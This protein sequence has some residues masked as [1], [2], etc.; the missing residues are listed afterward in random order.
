MC[1]QEQGVQPYLDAGVT[2]NL[3]ER[4]REVMGL[5]TRPGVNAMGCLSPGQHLLGSQGMG[6]SAFSPGRRG[7]GQYSCREQLLGRDY[8]LALR[9]R[10]G[11]LPADACW[12]RTLPSPGR[13]TVSLFQIRIFQIRIPD[14]HNT[15]QEGQEV[16]G[17]TVNCVTSRLATPGSSHMPMLQSTPQCSGYLPIFGLHPSKY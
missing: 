9:T 2:C 5:P 6:S 15:P 1:Y 8:T 16:L 4:G 12:P 10:V 7:K 14:F 13:V 11:C 17:Q 3:I